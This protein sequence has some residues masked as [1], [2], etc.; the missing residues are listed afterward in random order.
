[1]PPTR[2]DFSPIILR[3][4]MSRVHSFDTSTSTLVGSRTNSQSLDSDSE[5]WSFLTPPVCSNAGT[6]GIPPYQ[7]ATLHPKRKHEGFDDSEILAKKLRETTR[8][9]FTTDA[10]RSRDTVTE[11]PFL[12]AAFQNAQDQLNFDSVAGLPIGVKWEIARLVSMGRLATLVLD[13]L[14][15]LKGTN[16]EAA[17]RTVETILKEKGRKINVDVAFAAERK[18]QCPWEELDAEEAALSYPKGYGGKVSFVGSIEEVENGPGAK[19][20][21]VLDRCA[22]TSSSRLC[23]RFGSSAILRLKVPLKLLH[24]ADKNLKDFFRKPF[25][26]LG[27]V[28]RSFYAKDGTVFLFKTREY[29]SDGI[30]HDSTAGLSLF[31]FLD[32]FNP[33]QLN[34]NQALCK[35]ASRFALGLSNSV[36]GP[37]LTPDNVDE[38]GDIISPEESNMTDG[39]GI[40]NLAFNLKLRFDFNLETMPCA[41]QVR[42]GGRKGMLLLYPDSTLEATPKIAFRTPSQVKIIYSEEAKAHPANATVDILRFSRTTCPARLSPE[43]IINLEH[44]GVP[45]E[46][47]VR[48]QQ[49]YIAQAVDDLLFWAKEPGRDTPE[50]MLKLWTAVE[51]AEGVYAARRVREAAGEARFRGFG[52]RLN[53]SAQEEEEEEF[54]TAINERSTAWWPDYISGCPSSLAETCMVL[55][56][57]G[58]TPQSL[59]VLREKLKQ[60]VLKKIKYRSSHFRYEVVQSASAFVVPDC[61]DVLEENEIHF[62]SSRRHFLNVEGLETDTVEGDVLMTRNP[63]KVP[64]DVRKVKAVKHGMLHDLVD[65]IVCSVK[66]QRRL[67]D[68][69][70]GGDYDGDTA[71]VMWDQE[72][73]GSFVNAPEKYSVEPQ[74]IHSCFT[75][76][77]AE[78]QQYLLGSLRDPSAV[79]QYSGYHEN[80]IIKHGYDNHRTI[81]LAYQFCKIL[82][83]PKTGFNLRPETRTADAKQHGHARGP[84][85]KNRDKTAIGPALNASCL[86]RKVD[87]SNPSLARPFIMDVLNRAAMSQKDIWLKDAEDLFRQFEQREVTMDPDLEKPWHDFIEFVNQRVREGDKN[88]KSD[89]EAI[90]LHVVNMSRRHSEAIKSDAFTDQ[91]IEV[92]QDKLRLLSQDFAAAPTPA[93]LCTIFDPVAIARLRAS[94]AYIA[95][96]EKY[97]NGLG[98]SRFPWDVAS[99]D[100]CRIKA[101]ALGPNKAVTMKF[102]ER[103]K[104]GGERR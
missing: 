9:N 70:G 75:P 50:V 97:K 76:K 73:V 1:M 94:Y 4:E 32:E 26:I 27:N 10:T 66:G 85:W 57:S 43:V 40:S 49:A 51:K 96:F 93:E 71:I 33:L 5:L 42:H 37:V 86:E 78:L 17:P 95:D 81:K 59:P 36:P 19:L 3:A 98:W 89:L 12:I 82:D 44:N 13:D 2:F 62:K 103:F 91:A 28:F 101:D 46:V 47:F 34:A 30:I 60:V 68:F 16:T 84:L 25:I 54:D 88:P 77:A 48:M 20:K 38:F 52:E 67:L 8:I 58:F 69:L 100:L 29:Y 92:R 53:N 21:V 7:N 11:E 83:S 55:I 80:S 65:V 99:G 102:Y 56:D 61:W 104:L 79:G 23:R 87:R 72:I 64:T 6:N 15:Q 35:W 31:D 45:A 39:C 41:V 18:S 63:C 90:G 24:S 22:L 74:G 14:D